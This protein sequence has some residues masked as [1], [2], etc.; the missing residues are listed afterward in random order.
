MADSRVKL[1][2]SNG[3]YCKKINGKRYYFGKDYDHAVERYLAEREYLEKGLPL[4]SET[5]N[6]LGALLNEFL[7]FNL[8]KLQ[9]GELAARTYRDYQGICVTIASVIPNSLPIVEL[10]P[11]H[12]DALRPK[13]GMGVKRKLSKKSHNRN[14]GYARTVFRF[15]STDN[16]LIDRPLPYTNGLRSVPAKDLRRERSTLPPRLLTSD[17]LNLVLNVASVKFRAIILLAINGGF[18]NSDVAHLPLALFDSM[19]T[20][21]DY[22]RHKNYL[23]RQT[24]LWPETQQA[25]SDWLAIRPPCDRPELFVTAKLNAYWGSS[26]NDQIGKSFYR[27]LKNLGIYAPGKNFG[28]IRSTFADIIKEVGDD[29]A[30]KALMGHVD[31]SQMYS[32]YA[33]GVYLPRLKK[34]TEHVRNWLMRQILC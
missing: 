25:I 26:R 10:K 16:R 8:L 2:L 17:E 4:P 19:P 29:S 3:Y 13:L 24:P 27:Y 14:L 30:A 15:A 20:L 5:G 28:A 9:A 22:P 33:R 34:C 1:T 32:S 12:F 6:S 7:S 31:G 18:N 23:P 21:L 11:A